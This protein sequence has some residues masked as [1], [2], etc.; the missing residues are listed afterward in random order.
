MN[1]TQLTEHVAHTLAAQCGLVSTAPLLVAL[2]GGCDSVALLLLLR[3]NHRSVT[4]AH[5]NF[6]LRGEES[7]RDEAFCRAL[8]TRLGVA[9]R[10]AHFDTRAEAQ[11]HGESVEMAA[12]RLRY[13]WF[14]EV[15]QA[16]GATAIAVAHHRD[17]NVETMLLNLTRGTGIHGLTGMAYRRENVVRPLLDVPQADLKAFLQAERQDYVTDS[18]NADV[19][20]KRNFVRHRLLPLLRELNPSVES[21]LVS[22][23]RRLQVAE[24]AYDGVARSCLQQAIR[25]DG[26]TYYIDLTK[27]HYRAAF[28][29]LGAAFGFSEDAVKHLYAWQSVGERAV[30]EGRDFVGVVRGNVMEVC[31]RSPLFPPTLLPDEGSAT[32][33][34]GRHLRIRRQSRAELGDIPRTPWRVAIDADCVRGSLAYRATAQGDRFAPF[35]MKGRKAVSD[36]LTDRHVSAPRR[37]WSRVVT[38]EAGILWLVGERIDSRAAVTPSTQRVVLLEF[39]ES[40]D[41][42][43]ALNLF[44]T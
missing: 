25:Q 30:F 33:P 35:G 11:A 29:R 31:R 10:V 7:N 22:V 32:L 18:T 6:H 20:F 4:A 28:D 17:D 24:E 8:C 43:T 38:D 9:L 26:H 15:R 13:A 21:T 12:R 34:D 41:S 36:F 39:T 19:R 37:Q 16:C 42:Q 5:C 27:M 3:R 40:R 1:T 23:V 14:E 2:S 44:S